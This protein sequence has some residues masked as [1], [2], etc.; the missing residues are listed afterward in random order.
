MSAMIGS[1]QD[2]RW[3]SWATKLGIAVIG[4]AIGIAANW[5]WTIRRTP[6]TRPQP[7]VIDYSSAEVGTLRRRILEAKA[8]GENTVQLSVLGCGWEIGTLQHELSTDTVVLA[9]LVGKK[10]YESNFGLHTWYRFRIKETLVEHPYPRLKY[11]P[12]QKGPADMQPTADDEFL[13]QESNGELEIDGVTVTQR[14]NGPRY[15]EGQTYLLFL[16]IEPS[17]RTAIRSATDPVGV[18]LIDSDGNLRPYVDDPP[19]FAA[20]MQ[21]RFKNSV[22][23]LREALRKR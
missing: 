13:I 10:T 23:K 17:A 9:E 18:F 16:W 1:R 8:R 12:F 6:P 14:S 7:A 20:E 3:S 2:K 4:F 15:R 22:H 11:S 19:Q 21:N 5:A